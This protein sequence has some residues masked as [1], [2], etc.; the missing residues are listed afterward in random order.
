M[1]KPCDHC[2]TADYK[3]YGSDYFKCDK[4]CKRAKICKKNDEQLMKKLEEEK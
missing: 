2:N 3:K 1:T 4:P